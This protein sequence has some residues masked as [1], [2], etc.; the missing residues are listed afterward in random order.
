MKKAVLDIIRKHA[1]I[2]GRNN[3]DVNT[4]DEEIEEGKGNEMKEGN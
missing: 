2:R 4:S 1:A 3:D